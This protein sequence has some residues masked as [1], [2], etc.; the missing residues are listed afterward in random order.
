MIPTDHIA[1][2]RR[3]WNAWSVDYAA[4]GR[5]AW[6]REPTW[7]NWSIPETEVNAIGNVR[8]ADVIELGC[9]TAYWSAWL[10]RRGAR[11]TGI[12][13]SERQLATARELQREFGLEFPLV[14]AN[15]EHL[16][17]AGRRFDLAFS[18][19]GASIWCDPYAWIPEAA[20]VL[21]AD[22]RLIFLANAPLMILTSPD[23]DTVQ[24]A[25]TELLRPYFGLRACTWKSD[26]SVNF[27]LPH[28]EMLRLLRANGFEV[29]DLIELQAPDK[30]DRQGHP[31]IATLE[32]ARQWPTEEIWVARLRGER[33]QH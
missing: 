16:P 19:Y 11:P 25:G 29:E 15:A 31:H 22:G 4:A 21:R 17:I 14:Q 2:N 6:A 26:E 10:A 32:W 23:E 13:L 9:G 7:G 5:R 20:R 28:G 1:R 8:D 12:D 30:P 27:L 24:P 3:Q 33:D 18:E